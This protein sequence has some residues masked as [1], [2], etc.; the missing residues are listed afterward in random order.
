MTPLFEQLSALIPYEECPSAG[1]PKH[2]TLLS[3]SEYWPMIANQFEA[4]L[5]EK[6]AVTSQGW[7]NALM[8]SRREDIE[9][10]VL[11]KLVDRLIFFAAQGNFSDGYALLLEVFFLLLREMLREG[12]LPSMYPLGLLPAPK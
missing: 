11:P 12:K 1:L 7:V 5:A 10:V 8:L 2:V 3:A 4:I 6:E 9:K